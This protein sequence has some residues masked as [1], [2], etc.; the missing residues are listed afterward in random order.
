MI[1]DFVTTFLA[2]SPVYTLC[3]YGTVDPNPFTFTSLILIWKKIIRNI[4][5]FFIFCLLSCRLQIIF[6]LFFGRIYLWYSS[7]WKLVGKTGH[8]DMPF[9]MDFVH[10]LVMMVSL[11][12]NGMSFL[13]IFH[14]RDC[15]VSRFTD[16]WA[17]IVC[18][19]PYNNLIPFCLRPLLCNV[20]IFNCNYTTPFTIYHAFDIVGDCTRT[21]HPFSRVLRLFEVF[22][23]F[24]SN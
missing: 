16:S 5:Y 8:S 11:L 7:L 21:T 14:V 9:T 19:L 10:S 6:L 3:Q 17:L 23:M 18:L 1:R 13:P 15:T 4:P 12:W 2:M 20:C 24:A 22:I